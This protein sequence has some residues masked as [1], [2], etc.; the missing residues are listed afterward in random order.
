MNGGVV[1]LLVV[2]LIAGMAA[3]NG[4]V[5]NGGPSGPDLVTK[6]WTWE[7]LN[8]VRD[9]PKDSY[10]LM[11]S[12]NSST[13]GYGT[14]FNGQQG[15]LPIGTSAARFTGTF[16]GGGHTIEDL[17]IDRGGLDHVGLFGYVGQGGHVENITV[18]ATVVGGR[19]TGV[20]VGSNYEGTVMKATA[21][22]SVTGGDSVGGLVGYVWGG[23]VR[24]SQS[25]AAVSSTGP[26]RAGGLVGHN[27]LKGVIS[28]CEYTLGKVSGQLQVGGLVGLNAGSVVG[29]TG[30]GN[31]TG[32][33]VIGGVAGLS[34]RSGNLNGSKFIGYV[35]GKPYVTKPLDD[36]TVINRLS[37]DVVTA[38]SYIGGLVGWN[39]GR[40]D[41][42]SAD[43]AVFGTQNAGGLV[44]WNDGDGTWSRQYEQEHVASLIGYRQ[45][46]GLS[47]DSLAGTIRNSHSTGSVT[48]VS[49]VGGLV[50]GNEGFVDSCFSA[51]KVIGAADVGG[52]VG[53]SDDSKGEVTNSFWDTD[54]SGQARSAG[55]IGSTSAQLR[56]INTYRTLGWDICAVAPGTVNTACTWN[57]VDGE[58]PFLSGK[59]SEPAPPPPPPG[60]APRTTGPWV[61]SILITEESD[62]AAAIAKLWMGELDICAFPINDVD[63]L[64]TVLDNPNIDYVGSVGS[65]NALSFNPVPFFNDGRFNPFGFPQIR[66][67]VNK[68]V[69]RDYI[70]SEIQG[71]LGIPKY[72]VLNAAFADAT[73]RYPDLIATTASAYAHN[74]AAAEVEISAEMVT[75]GAY[76]DGTKGTW[77]YD[78][79]ELEIIILIGAQDRQLASVGHYL[80]DQLEEI[81]FKSRYD[82]NYH[83]L[84]HGDPAAGQFHIYAGGG[85]TSTVS[86]DQGGDFAFFYTD[87]G[88]PAPLSQAYDTDPDFYETCQKL[89]VNDF[90]TLE[91]RR[92]LFSKALTRSLK[93]SVRIWL[94]DSYGFSAFSS[95]VGLSADKAGGIA[96]SWMWA[97]TVHFKGADGNPT[98]GGNLKIAV[99]GFL[100]VPVNPIAG[101]NWVYDMFWIR[102][103]G[104]A[105]WAI[106][107][108]DGLRWPHRFEKAEVTVKT[109]LPV[110][111]STALGHDWVTLSF[112]PSIAVPGDAWADWDAATQ[113]F[114]SASTRFPGGT[115]ALRKSVVYYPKDIF[116]MPLHD[117]S[118]LSMGDFII[119]AILTFDRAKEASPIYDSS[120]VP[121]FN[122]FMSAFKGVRF[123]TDSPD[124]GLIVE[125]YSD[126]WTMDAELLA[127]HW[128]PVYSQGPA[129]WHT[130]AVAIRAEADKQ[131]AFSS[132]KANALG[133]EWTSFI[134]GPSLG[135]LRNQLI[136]AKGANYIPYAPTMGRYV[137]AEEAAER[138]ANLAAWSAPS[139]RG[140]FWVATGPFYL[141]AA[142]PIAKAV[143][144]TRFEDYPDKVGRFNFMVSP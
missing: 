137:T 71:G 81:G 26:R 52:L 47:E 3:C 111:V 123:I 100:S 97:H 76:I 50:G 42:C 142:F 79:Q 8:N 99:P 135:I 70:A 9:R 136:L 131:L 129:V 83:V 63:L 65:Y 105:G 103:T 55:G 4:S 56:D 128:W 67:A 62:S 119:S 33:S 84:W 87:M 21:A 49:Y 43:S 24:Q 13:P 141:E 69:D 113:Q 41:G 18:Y 85:V 138:Y 35:D 30:T 125:T 73:E 57:I 98:L 2:A 80:G 60:P 39:E 101:S 90:T 48:G 126:F 46:S 106:D 133:V 116:E 118:T 144:L 139:G 117:G 20:L 94:T 37:A 58:Y 109:G 68:L 86:R 124:W 66:E 107:T 10:R 54:T 102:A 11:N 19:N 75:R 36:G 121:S 25:S 29:C 91:E 89:A 16:D 15:W 120:A 127:T 72:T 104:D 95:N 114:I 17:Y 23:S 51:G 28:D 130:L 12:L 88:Y 59:A 64:A 38:G 44:G 82:Y 77:H 134:A 34:L 61:D 27:S 115:T 22:G 31:V 108:R 143:Q 40:I 112:A 132:P 74:K 122:S 92:A 93:D 53:W 45:V 32:V 140:H 14:F 96:G 6:I 110:G 1:F 5:G 7:D 78:G